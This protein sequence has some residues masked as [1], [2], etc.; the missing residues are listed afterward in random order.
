M[1]AGLYEKKRETVGDF[2][3]FVCNEVARSSENL[4]YYIYQILRCHI[5]EHSVIL[6]SS[7]SAVYPPTLSFNP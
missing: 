5:P 6:D 7:D 3:G 1:L 4:T 2:T